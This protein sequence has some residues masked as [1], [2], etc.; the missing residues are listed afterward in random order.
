[1]G[2]TY[3]L[4]LSWPI[5]KKIGDSNKTNADNISSGCVPSAEALC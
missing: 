3:I 2:M 1:M 5:A 4:N